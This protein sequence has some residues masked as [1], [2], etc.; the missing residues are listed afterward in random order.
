M[1][2]MINDGDMSFISSDDEDYRWIQDDIDGKLILGLSTGCE[3]LD[4]ALSVLSETSQSSTVSQNIGKSTFAM[5]M[6]VSSAVLH[7]WRWV[8]YSA[9]NRTAAVKM[10]LIQFATNV[11]VKDLRATSCIKKAYQVG[12]R[13]LH[14]HQQQE[15]VLLH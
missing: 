7:D 8:I 10:K 3:N 14:H 4:K 5:Y 2:M 13:S 9:E 11:P 15:P 6:I 12:G 1:E